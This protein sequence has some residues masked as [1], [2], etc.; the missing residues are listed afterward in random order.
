MTLLNFLGKA[1]ERARARPARDRES[2]CHA[3]NSKRSNELQADV[4]SVETDSKNSLLKMPTPQVPAST[5]QIEVQICPSLSKHRPRTLPIP[6]RPKS[7]GNDRSDSNRCGYFP[8]SPTEK[9]DEMRQHSTT[10]TLI[11][12][13]SDAKKSYP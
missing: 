2:A 5:A 3:S 12:R 10:N 13:K 8:S 11:E 1:D 6:N 4:L 9:Q 7:I